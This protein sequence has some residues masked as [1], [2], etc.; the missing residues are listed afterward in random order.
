[1]ITFDQFRTEWETHRVGD[2]SLVASGEESNATKYQCVSL[3]KQYVREC[4]ELNPG[5]WGNAIQWWSATNP[6]VLTKFTKDPTGNVQKGDIVILRTVGHIDY[7]GYGHIGIATGNGDPNSI[8]ILEQNGLGSGSGLGGDAIRTRYVAR[9]RLAGVLRPIPIA[10][11]LPTITVTSFA[12]PTQYTVAGRP[13]YNLD[14]ANFDE[15]SSQPLFIADDTV[16]TVLA[17]LTR[18]DL[19]QYVYY[20][21]DANAHYGYNKLDC[22]PY[23]P[24]APYV[25]PATPNKGTP[26]E[27]YEVFVTLDGF[28][29]ASDA[30]RQQNFFQPVAPGSNYFVFARDI[31][32]INITKD[33][34]K[35]GVWINPKFN[36]LPPVPAP[37]PP[38]LPVDIVQPDSTPVDVAPPPT[39][40]EQGSV[41]FV[42]HSLRPD[43][44]PVMYYANNEV[45]ID[46][47]DLANPSEVLH[48]EPYNN[49]QP[50]P[51]VQWFEAG[52]VKYYRAQKVAK[53]GWWYGIRADILSEVNEDQPLDFNRDGKV[54]LQDIG[55]IIQD[56]IVTP[57]TRAYSKAHKLGIVDKAVHVT[58]QAKQQVIDGFT[59]RRKQ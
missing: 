40:E 10:P 53:A 11:P 16:I 43:G 36:E 5:A 30:N 19:P 1:M 26:P 17:Y 41:N 9:N 14:L 34:M 25:P 54:N 4:Y 58:T 21:E 52:G 20:L 38:S 42:G 35:A 18:S 27:T 13:K 44:K 28:Q 50:I 23:T 7:A 46:I 55:Y 56:Y 12:A 15:I 49:D 37:V 51:V 32:M 8:E 3:V 31:G 47:Q 29:S 2:D 59:A 39:L 22:T 24:P 45:P 6:A 57:A 48:M 33:N